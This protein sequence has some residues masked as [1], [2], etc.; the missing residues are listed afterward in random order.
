MYPFGTGVILGGIV[1][2]LVALGVGLWLIGGRGPCRRRAYR[3]A[4]RFLHEGKWQ[5]ALAAVREVQ[6]LGPLSPSWE[7]RARHIEGECQRAAGQ[8]FLAAKDHEKSLEHFRAAACLLHLDETPFREC[9]VDALLG[10][11]RG[12]FAANAG[13]VHPLVGRLLMLHSPCPE[14]SFWQG[15]AHLRDGRPDLALPALRAAHEGSGKTF[16][17]PPFYLGALQLRNGQPQEAL[18]YLAE[19]NRIDST[20]PFVIWQLGLAIVAAGGDPGLAVR[21]LQRALGQ[22][23]LALWVRSPEKAWSEGFP[24]PQ[25]SFVARLARQ[26][27]FM[28]PLLGGD[29]AA[30]IRQGFLAL[31]QAQ[32]RLGNHQ[33]AANIY[34]NLLQE[35]A[36]SLPVLRG[37]G[38]ALAKLERFDEAFKHLKTAHDLEGPKAP[39]TAGY[40]ALCGAR[41]KPSR[42][43]D[44]PNNVAWAIR[45]LA[46]FFL[47]KD[48]EWAV[49]YRQV[50]A[51]ARVHNVPVAVEDQVR[52]CDVLAGVEATDADAAAAYDQL[53]VSAAAAVKPV[54]A[55]LYGRAAQQ[56]FRGQADLDLLA[57]AFRSG[58]ALREFFAQRQ[59]DA[60]ELEALY[61]ARWAERHPGGFPDVFGSGYPPRGEKLLLARAQQQETAGKLDEALATALTLHRLAPL[62]NRAH[63]RLAC[64]YYRKGNLEEAVRMLVNWEALHPADPWPLLR[65]AVLEQKRGNAVGR[66]W[67]MDKALALASGPFRAEVAYLGARLALNHAF[68]SPPIKKEGTSGELQQVFPYLEEC[69]KEQPGHAG[70]L[71]LL[72]ALRWQT[73]NRAA[74]AALAP[75]TR[76]PDVRTSGFHYLAAVCQLTAG[77]PVQAIES[78]RRVAEGPLAVESHYLIGLAHARLHNRAAVADLEKVAR[79]PDSPSADH[80]RALLGRLHFQDGAY[81]E[82]AEWWSALD[83]DKRTAWQLEEPLRAVVFLAGLQA[84]QSGKHEQ[85][86]EKYR[87]AGKLGW[88]DRRLGPLL[89]RAL[90]QAGQRLLYAGDTE[91]DNAPDHYPRA[92]ALLA[93]AIQVGCKDP[94]AHYL[95]AIAH[96]RQGKIAEAR[97][98]FRKILD[99]DANLWLQMGLLSLREKQ[100]AQ[101]EP[102]FGKAW[103]LAPNDF[104]AGANLLLTRLSLGQT[105]W[106]AAIASQVAVLA[107]RP[108][109]R[110]FFGLLQALLWCVQ[111]GGGEGDAAAAT[112]ARM[113]D[114]DEQRLIQLIRG[115]GHLDT[116]CLLFRL[117]SAARPASA[118][119]KEAHFEAVL[120]KG[121]N[122]LD[123]CEW[124]TAERLLAVLARDA[125]APAP[126]RAAL[127]NLLG[128][129]A[130]LS[131]DFEEG[132]RSFAAA[133]RLSGNDAGIH[134]N[135]A[136]VHE[137][138]RDPVQAEPHWNRYFDLLERRL[139]GTVHPSDRIFQLLYQGLHRLAACYMEKEK[140]GQAIAFVERAQRLG[141]EDA[142]TLE[143]LFHLYSQVRRIDDA[144]R[145][146]QQL[147]RLRPGEVQF[148]LYELDLIELRDIDDLDR[149]ISEIGRIVQ[150]HPGE[151]KV[152]E[153]GVTMIGNAIPLLLRIC[154]QLTDQ[155][156]KIIQQVRD[157]QNYQID[158]HAVHEVMRELKREFQNLRKTIGKFL[159]VVTNSE[160]R[161]VLR[162]LAAHI[163]RKIE[164]C[165]EWQGN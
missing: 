164:F 60:D 32:H 91:K 83:A 158:W 22:R 25:K 165:R 154:D 66:A 113:N 153:R 18:R 57:S 31:G 15:L 85:A 116:S 8:A 163:D 49:I 75:M 103:E 67:A 53:A 81:L 130:C 47:D 40:L 94:A 70:A 24:G 61:L 52:C 162:D 93:Q 98:A 77:D 114:D 11:I 23:G 65:R 104:A 101:A 26:H 149:W 132:L 129:C 45:L 142:D 95:L 12:L 80:A 136:L 127:L 107:R 62:D 4:R 72:A 126:I 105:E 7:G 118:W 140:W 54:H 16:V 82:A 79:T 115:L 133:V 5:E 119:L 46:R 41:A 121:K 157:L 3:R 84:H 138:R 128:C 74:V 150:C 14:A 117:L 42:P 50:F 141:P 147:R 152:E 2:L 122:L 68:S 111:S 35:A 13:S 148:E 63:D 109:D 112:L 27:P 135:L 102:E 37:L 87:E 146:L 51:E 44:K 89:Q 161:R 58:A 33:E 100:P 73:G 88:R 90:F 36:P 108:E 29:I 134:H 137:W 97:A 86:A 17:D 145:V 59:W 20:C 139:N 124:N 9:V 159:G 120:L 76:R 69:L 96:K 99:G 38:L 143:R 39:L 48:A 10:D 21:A 6:A 64:L 131:Q 160:Q 144:R 71:T 110:R 1:L 19:A 34:N 78:A 55:W 156:N 92:A 43:A 56:G 125:D 30:M 151:S 28:C 123:R 155:V 106:A